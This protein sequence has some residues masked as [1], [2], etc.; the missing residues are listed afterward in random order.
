MKGVLGRTD[1]LALALLVSAAVCVSCYARNHTQLEGTY[2]FTADEIVRD[3]CAIY[4]GSSALWS[5]TMQIYGDLVRIK[6][7]DR[8]YLMQA[9]GFFLVKEERFTADGSAGNITAN[10]NGVG[11][12]MT[13]INAHLDSTTDSE[14]AFHG[15][16]RIRY[17]SD[18]IGCTCEFWARFSASLQ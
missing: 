15:S 9:V 7:D 1:S 17:E 8:L 16:T 14:R 4:S 10:A 2:Q 3:E 18:Q 5:G 12:F 11:C 13:I 6:M